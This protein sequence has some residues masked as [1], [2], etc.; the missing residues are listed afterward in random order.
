MKKLYFISLLLF[1]FHINL[2]CID[3]EYLNILNFETV[4][5]RLDKTYTHISK[6]IIDS[7]KSFTIYRYGDSYKYS[8]SNKLDKL[9]QTNKYYIK[10]NE[11]DYFAFENNDF[12]YFFEGEILTLESQNSN[13]HK[14]INNIYGNN[15]ASDDFRIK[16]SEDNYLYVYWNNQWYKCGYVN[17][18]NED[19]NPVFDVIS[20]NRILFPNYMGFFSSDKTKVFIGSGD[21]FIKKN[22]SEFL[23]N[24]VNPDLKR[25]S[26]NIN[27][28]NFE[29]SLTDFLLTYPSSRFEKNGD[30]KNYIID[31]FNDFDSITLYFTGEE[32]S[33]FYLTLEENEA[34][35]TNIPVLV[36][37]SIKELTD[38]YGIPEILEESY[39]RIYATEIQRKYFW[40]GEVCI[41]LKYEYNYMPKYGIV[42][43]TCEILC[44]LDPFNVY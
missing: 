18:F 1:L 25:N 35:N 15:S 23:Y 16:I 37:K 21:K 36:Q 40:S 34:K 44:T 4:K 2:F 30:S 14:I 5:N 13:T 3:Y 42:A 32:L 26:V 8:S 10:E 39:D 31:N 19:A 38:K 43:P 20:D 6:I 12:L 11:T 28:I 7:E 24:Y 29:L 22:K 27:N 9:N 41:E 17:L 33:Y